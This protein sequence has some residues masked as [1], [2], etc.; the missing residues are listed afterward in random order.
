MRKNVNYVVSSPP[1]A[2]LQE[3]AAQKNAGKMHENK[4]KQ[5]LSSGFPMPN[6]KP[7]ELLLQ[8]TQWWLPW[9]HGVKPIATSGYPECL[10]RR[11]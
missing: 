11:R 7:T 9:R 4:Q 8:H 2:S 1:T 5:C 10:C 6:P 3:K